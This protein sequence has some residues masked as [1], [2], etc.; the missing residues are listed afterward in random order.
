[1]EREQKAR[2]TAAM[3]QSV[4]ISTIKQGKEIIDKFANVLVE[5]QPPA[6]KQGKKDKKGSKIKPTEK[7]KT[8]L[9][10]ESCFDRVLHTL[11]KSPAKPPRATNIA[12]TKGMFDFIC[13]MPYILTHSSYLCTFS[14]FCLFTKQNV[15]TSI[16]WIWLRVPST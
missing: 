9:L 12:T 15:E 1:M 11:E 4:G 2:K 5:P 10:V 16:T 3:V 7:E 13:R 8:S 6:E 14:I